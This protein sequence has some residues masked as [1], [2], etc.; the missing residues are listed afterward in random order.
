MKLTS[1][2]SRGHGQKSKLDSP[3][4]AWRDQ[5]MP[6]PLWHHKQWDPACGRQQQDLQAGITLEDSQVVAFF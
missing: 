6:G 2:R 1:P 5:S 3:K 4:R